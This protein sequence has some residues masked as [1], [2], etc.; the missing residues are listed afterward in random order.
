MSESKFIA[1]RHILKSKAIWRRRI[2]SQYP[3]DERN[4]ESAELL[5]A[6][7]NASFPTDAATR[8][9]GIRSADL[10]RATA[11]IAHRIPFWFRPASIDELLDLIIER[12]AEHKAE[13]N[14]V[15]GGVR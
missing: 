10:N 14:R 3:G 5:E 8:I 12:A 11:E 15:F 4:I 2:A 9:E 6:L 13:L 1:I 7:A